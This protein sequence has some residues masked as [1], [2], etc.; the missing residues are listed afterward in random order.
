M[1]ERKEVEKW[2]GVKRVDGVCGVLNSDGVVAK[3]AHLDG[4]MRFKTI[5]TDCLEAII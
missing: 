3:H 4:C 5:K 1:R 2:G